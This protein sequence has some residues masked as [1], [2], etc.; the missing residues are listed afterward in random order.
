MY[1]CLSLL[2]IQISWFS[3]LL[4]A[5]A[6]RTESS[7][8]NG[9]EA[10]MRLMMSFDWSVRWCVCD[11]V[12]VVQRSSLGVGVTISEDR[13]GF[14]VTSMNHCESLISRRQRLSCPAQL[15]PSSQSM[16]NASSWP[17]LPS[18]SARTSTHTSDAI[19]I[20]GWG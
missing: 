10:I 13:K 8:R 1:V 18:M 7:S 15:F 16:M 17:R 2:L 6:G 19:L 4:M 12:D 14:P 9:D 5:A 11:L 20:T 3:G